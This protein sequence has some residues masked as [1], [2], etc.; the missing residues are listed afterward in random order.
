MIKQAKQLMSK[1]EDQGM[2]GFFM[3]FFTK[4]TGFEVDSP[5]YAEVY[6]LVAEGKI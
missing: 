3:D 2:S 5:E 4:Q 1:W 6:E